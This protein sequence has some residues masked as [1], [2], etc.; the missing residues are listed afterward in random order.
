M[1]EA[2][3]VE[4]ITPPPSGSDDSDAEGFGGETI[5]VRPP[6]LEAQPSEQEVSIP[7]QRRSQRQPKRGQN[8]NRGPVRAMLAS[9]EAPQTLKEALESE[10]S[11]HWREVWVSE[12]D[13]LAR[14]NTWRLEPLPPGRQAIGC[15]WLFQRKEDGRYKAR[16]VAKGYSQCEGVDFMETFAPV[17]KFNSLRSLLALV[18]EN[19]WELEGMDVKTAFLNSELEE[20]VYMDIPEGLE[21]DTPAEVTNQQIACRLIKSIY[22]L[23]QS[24]R[25]W[26]GKINTFFHNHG[27]HRSE[28]DHNVYIHSFFKLILFL[29]VDD[30]VITAPRLEDG[31]WIRGLLHEE[32]AMTDLGPLTGFLGMEICRNRVLQNLHLSQQRYIDN[33]LDR[34]GMS[35]AATVSTPSDPHVRLPA[36][37]ADHVAD[38]INQ[39]RYQAAVGSLMY[40]MIGIRP[41][42]AFALSIVSQYSYNPGPSHCTA[43][44]RIFRYLSG[45]RTHG[46]MYGAGD[47]GGYTDADWGAGEDRKSIGGYVF[48]INGGAISWASKKQTS[49]ASSST[50]AE[51][52]VL[53][54]GIKESLWLGNLLADIG[55]LK[56]RK[57]IQQIQ[58]DNQGA[59][60]LSKNSEYH[61]RTKHID[62]QYHLIRQHV[63]QGTIELSYCPTHEMTADIFTKPLPRPQFEKHVL[64]FGLAKC[65]D[66][67]NDKFRKLNSYE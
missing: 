11:T 16:L 13:S 47:C 58:G 15:R 3:P 12:V 32:C 56:Y 26:Y 20:R 24:P 61:A 5:V 46:I 37:P 36:S 14:N 45:T 44:R 18:C 42:I 31:D 28:R 27:F 19:N 7:T 38:S 9:M 66:R 43:V 63:E 23:K 65:P 62:I 2:R 67:Q 29:Y 6:N 35:M 1:N 49:V 21:I 50:E 8:F 59:L 34:F 30:L 40:A 60:A 25:A 4:R 57:A 48:L 33:I 55:A 22:G 52:M 10:G 54:Q 53:T 51:Y 64:G 39:Q 41:D 17:A